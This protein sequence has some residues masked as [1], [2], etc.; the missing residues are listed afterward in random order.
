VHVGPSPAATAAAAADQPPATIADVGVAEFT[1]RSHVHKVLVSR[2]LIPS[3]WALSGA[4]RFQRAH[5]DEECKTLVQYAMQ[6]YTL[7]YVY[8]RQVILLPTVQVMLFYSAIFIRL[9]DVPIR[10][11]ITQAANVS[12]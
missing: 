8:L 1:V 7:D 11:Q 5:L 2:Q 6:Y 3:L 9:Y 12:L 4:D 10:N